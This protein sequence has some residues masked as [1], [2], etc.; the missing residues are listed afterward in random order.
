M[1]RAGLGQDKKEKTKARRSRRE[2]FYATPRRF[3][4]GRRRRR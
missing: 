1:P 3:T 2:A 4:S